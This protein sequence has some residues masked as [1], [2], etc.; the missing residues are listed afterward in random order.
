[1]TANTFPLA[2]P[3]FSI[4]IPTYQRPEG[5]R[6]CLSGIAAIRTRKSEFEVIVV[7]DFSDNDPDYV[8]EPFESDLNL[9]LIHHPENR[10]P[11]AARNTGAQ[12]AVGDYLLFIDDD[13]IPS[14]NW[15]DCVSAHLREGQNRAVGGNCL[16][17]ITTSV[18][19]T[20]QQML[21]DYMYQYYNSDPDRARFCPTNNLAVPR[22]TFLAMGSFD[23]SFR[24]AAGEDRDFSERW[25]TSGAEMIFVRDAPVYHQHTMGLW[26]FIR[27]HYY[28]GRGARR[29]RC[30][31]AGKNV[32]RG[33]EPVRF[34]LGLVIFPFSQISPGR[35]TVLSTLQFL[36]QIVH[37]IGYLREF[38]AIR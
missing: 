19:S 23:T 30:K 29:F 35:A 34:Y 32:S 6:N 10:G 13:C 1:M 33:F 11:A 27:M 37:T 7:D 4:V 28:Y 38:S 20:A 17:G 31:E 22:E 5:L 2:A 36:S 15:I 25:I 12:Q 26:S 3:R 14:R 18:Y 24:Y 16:N 9:T 21:M 8:V